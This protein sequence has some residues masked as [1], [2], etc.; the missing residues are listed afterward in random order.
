MRTR[1]VLLLG[2]LTVFLP[3]AAGAAGKCDPDG[4]HGSAVLAA[5]E[6]LRESCDCAAAASHAAYVDCARA[7]IR[8]LAA[9]GALPRMCRARMMQYAVRSTCGH[10]QLKVCCESNDAFHVFPVIRKEGACR[11]R[12]GATCVSEFPHLEEAC[13]NAGT[14]CRD[15]WC[16]DGITDRPN[17]EQCEP[18]GVGLCD[19]SCRT[20]V[21]GNGTLD[22]GEECEPPGTATCSSYCTARNCGDGILDPRSEFCE[23]PNTPTC[24]ALCNRIYACGNGLVEISNGE[25][26]EP[27]GTATCDASCRFIHTCGNGVIEPG[28]ECD[29][30]ASCSERCRLFRS[31][32]CE[33]G[34]G[35]FGGGGDD[36]FSAYWN[37][38]KDCYIL[39]GTSSF[40]TCEGTEPCPAPYPPGL[41][42]VGSCEDGPI[43]PMP[44][45]CDE[46]DGTCR[47][48]VATKAS[49]LGSFGCSSFPPPSDGDVPHLILGTCGP[50]GRCVPASATETQP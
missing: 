15:S 22:P 21:C 45:C 19:P 6:A 40:G 23:P 13:T 8:E 36:D 5:R 42:V 43:D 47:D 12:R 41:C 16:G 2:L 46:I 11:I 18:P 33:Y 32:C 44:L 48:T 38:F 27:P 17:G 9:T 28:E 1:S 10:Q 26:C 49:D 35:C 37:V 4:V 39:G 30:Q 24:D 34:I 31:A 14:I 20:I 7:R 3:A 29:G 50:A 25:E